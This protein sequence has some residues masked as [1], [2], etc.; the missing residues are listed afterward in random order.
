[1]KSA[2]RKIAFVLAASGHGTLILNRFDFH[3]YEG[4]L[5]GVGGQI[6]EDG[7]FDPAEVDLVLALLRFRR[8]YFG[9]G[10]F[11]VDCGANIGV[12]TVEA[13]VAMVDWG[14]VLAI[15]AQE[16]I[17]YALAG[18]IAINNCFNAKAIHA[19]VAGRDGVM[20]IPSPD[21]LAEGSFGSLELRQRPQTEFIGQVV[22]YSE[23]AG[24]EVRCLALDSLSLARIDMIKMDIEGMEEEALEG[25]RCVI[26]EHKPI[27]LIEYIKS[28]KDRL[29]GAFAAIGYRVFQAGINLVMI[30]ADDPSADDFRA[31]LRVDE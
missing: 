25:A 18:N 13:A 27:M 10:V 3:R 7:A 22:D 20:R 8:R 24:Q 28:D 15:E 21:Y 4:G 5:Y 17:F 11:L 30:H 31:T 23:V 14:S 6:L 12:H 16:R 9:D 29:A 19:A 26:A 1:M 2:D